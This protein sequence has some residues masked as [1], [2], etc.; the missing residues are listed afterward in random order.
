MVDN[1][2]PSSLCRMVLRLDRVPQGGLLVLMAGVCTNDR[3]VLRL[4]PVL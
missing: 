2:L 1:Y 3:Q 4:V